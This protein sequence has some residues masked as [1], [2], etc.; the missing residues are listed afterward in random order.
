MV[1][2]RSLI[3]PMVV[4]MWVASGCLKR[5]SSLMVQL[6]ST[7]LDLWLKAILR[8]K[9]KISLVLTHLLLE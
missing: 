2:E 9:V 6:R 3:D 7:R 4:N 5:I 8:K 1:R